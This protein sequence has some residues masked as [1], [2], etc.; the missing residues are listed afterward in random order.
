M[1]STA[2]DV[3][4]LTVSEKPMEVGGLGQVNLR[5]QQGLVRARCRVESA[6]P[7]AGR[8]EVLLFRAFTS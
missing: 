4:Q 6:E 3:H 5:A 7:W 1:F 8:G 2:L